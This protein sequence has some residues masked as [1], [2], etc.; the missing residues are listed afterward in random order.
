MNQNL[1]E[2]LKL[3]VPEKILVV[4]AIWDNIAAE[5][6]NYEISQDEFNVLEERYE[7]YK[8]NPSSVLSWDEVKKNI[9]NGITNEILLAVWNK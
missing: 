9:L 5:N 2:I 4:E 7:A 3:S 8:A 6:C 1:S